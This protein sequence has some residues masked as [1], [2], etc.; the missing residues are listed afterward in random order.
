MLMFKKKIFVFLQTA[1]VITKQAKKQTSRSK[2]LHIHH[3][4]NVNSHSN[5]SECPSR[6]FSSLS[7]SSSWT[8]RVPHTF[9]L[10]DI[11]WD[12]RLEFQMFQLP[13]LG[14]STPQF[15]WR[16][17]FPLF[18]NPE[19]KEE[20]QYR[21][22]NVYRLLDFTKKDKHEQLLLQKSNCKQTD[23]WQSQDIKLEEN[24]IFN[25]D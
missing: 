8:C 20:I 3:A 4:F 23:L 13:F 9:S 18:Q 6:T 24:Q 5:N 17:P 15:C 1:G 2:I 7:F 22:E 10:A 25:Q 14:S 16:F 12:S 21:T 19:I 11:A